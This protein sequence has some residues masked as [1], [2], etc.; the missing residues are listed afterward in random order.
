SHDGRRNATRAAAPSRLSRDVYNEVTLDHPL[1]KDD[2]TAILRSGTISKKEI[3][4]LLT[5]FSH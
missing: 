2:L 3:Q 4:D 5:E 1:T